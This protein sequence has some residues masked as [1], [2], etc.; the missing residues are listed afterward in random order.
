MI[1]ATILAPT[2]PSPKPRL[3][4]SRFYAVF[5]LV[6]WCHQ[7]TLSPVNGSVPELFGAAICFFV[8]R[9]VIPFPFINVDNFFGRIHLHPLSGPTTIT[10]SYTH[11][12][13]MSI[14]YQY[15]LVSTMHGARLQSRA[16][17]TSTLACRL[18]SPLWPACTQFACALGFPTPLPLFLRV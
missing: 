14:P 9:I 11:P 2:L 1:R 16:S 6:G 10:P 18:A 7:S 17:L 12:M 15:I 3:P 13:V 4:G 8:G 5:P